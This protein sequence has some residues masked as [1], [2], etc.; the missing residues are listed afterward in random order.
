[1]IRS[2]SD[3]AESKQLLSSLAKQGGAADGAL[4]CFQGLYPAFSGSTNFGLVLTRQ[5]AL[6]FAGDEMRVWARFSGMQITTPKGRFR[7]G[8]IRL[9]FGWSNYARLVVAQGP[10]FWI[11]GSWEEAL[12]AWLNLGVII[13]D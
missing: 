13:T 8:D 1:V 9:A 11:D 12:G 3:D 7:R 4:P 5:R 10:K 2:M 6:T